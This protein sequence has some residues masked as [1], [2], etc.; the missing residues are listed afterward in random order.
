MNLDDE[1][2]QRLVALFGLGLFLFSWPLM[3]LFNLPQRWL[4]M[5]LLVLWLFGTW[6]ALIAAVAWVVERRA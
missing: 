3:A 2:V 6:A 4:G 1:Q 5:P